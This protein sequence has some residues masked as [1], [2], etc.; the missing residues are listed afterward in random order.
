[1][2][3]IDA[4]AAAII[5]ADIAMICHYAMLDAFACHIAIVTP[6]ILS[7]QR[8]TRRQAIIG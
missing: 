3:F 1:L 5:Y 4:Y 2:I 7:P 8:H 6:D